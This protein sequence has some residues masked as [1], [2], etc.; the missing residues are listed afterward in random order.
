MAEA[1]RYAGISPAP[2]GY[3]GRQLFLFLSSPGPLDEHP[4]SPAKPPRR[5]SGARGGDAGQGPRLGCRC[6]T[7]TVGGRTSASGPRSRRSVRPSPS[8]RPR[9]HQSPASPRAAPAR[10]SPRAA[11][12]ASRPAPPRPHRGAPRSSAAGF[13]FPAGEERKLLASGGLGRARARRAA[14]PQLPGSRGNGEARV[15]R[16]FLYPERAGGRREPA[17]PLGAAAVAFALIRPVRRVPCR[18]GVVA[19][20]WLVISGDFPAAG[21][22]VGRGQAGSGRV[23]VEGERP[24]LQ[25]PPVAPRLAAASCGFLP[26][27]GSRPCWVGCS[28]REL[29]SLVPFSSP[30]TKPVMGL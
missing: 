18:C 4:P 27:R 21:A 28:L 29:S 7:R 24:G 22:G 19:A 8:P 15:S 2:S 11:V 6:R 13:W 10:R 17:A 23:R 1:A 14:E 12:A 26:S 3:R 9:L 20:P 30:W 16:R 5:M 25:R